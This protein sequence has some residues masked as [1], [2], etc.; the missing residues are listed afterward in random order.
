MLMHLF[1]GLVN[2]KNYR[3]PLIKNAL[4]DKSIERM[5]G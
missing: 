2:Q 3:Y 4:N 5:C 1:F